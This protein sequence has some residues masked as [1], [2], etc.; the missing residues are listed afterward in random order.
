M[1]GYQR[2]MLG[3]FQALRPATLCKLCRR[4]I[5]LMKCCRAEIAQYAGLCKATRF[6]QY[7]EC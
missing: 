5:V 3:A 7:V 6:L 4:T 1:L 2:I